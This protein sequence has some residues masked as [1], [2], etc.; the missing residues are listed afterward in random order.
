MKAV[1]A[2]DCERGRSR[3]IAHADQDPLVPER[4]HRNAEILEAPAP[5]ASR[6]NHRFKAIEISAANEAA[7]DDAASCTQLVRVPCERLVRQVAG[8]GGHCKIAPD[9]AASADR[10]CTRYR[11]TVLSRRS[12]TEVLRKVLVELLRYKE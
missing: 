10:S 1:L 5:I 8:A 6:Q 12:H 3:Q 4:L 11:G 9:A 7:Y 2:E